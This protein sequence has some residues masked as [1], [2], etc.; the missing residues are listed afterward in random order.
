MKDKNSKIYILTIIVVVIVYFVIYLFGV[1]TKKS[2]Y[3]GNEGY[4]NNPSKQPVNNIFSHYYDVEKQIIHFVYDTER[5]NYIDLKNQFP[6][7][8]EV[9][10]NFE[11]DKYTQDFRLRFDASAL[12]VHYSIV[13]VKSPESDLDDDWVKTYLIADGKALPNCFRENGRVKTF[14]EY[15][16][17]YGNSNEKILYQGIITYNEAKR[18]YKD[19]TLKLWISEDVE[20]FNEDYLEKNFKMSIKVDAGRII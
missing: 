2:I 18:G 9:G 11:G 14:N 13:A 8:D 1:A 4:Y 20:V 6:T 16:D 12:L 19:F 3:S 5:G 10:M 17:Y 15:S 7:L